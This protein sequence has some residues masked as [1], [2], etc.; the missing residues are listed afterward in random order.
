MFDHL[1]L[2]VF[3]SDH[4]QFVPDLSDHV[5]SSAHISRVLLLLVRAHLQPLPPALA[6]SSRP[7]HLPDLV[8]DLAQS[9][10][11]LLESLDLIRYSV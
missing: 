1:D 9:L 11:H 10:L 3:L 2:C 6:H 8:P 5:P 7:T 4:L